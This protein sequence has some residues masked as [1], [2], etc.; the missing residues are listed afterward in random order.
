MSFTRTLAVT[1]LLTASALFGQHDEHHKAVNARGD[2]AMGFSHE[3]TTH[4]FLL[5][6]SG[7]IIRV[8]ANDA[9]DT[10]SRD[11][12]RQHLTHIAMMF[13]AG[14][15]QVPMLIH[16]QVPPGV[17]AM[18]Q[19]KTAISYDFENAAQGAQI[20]ITTKDKK[21]VKAIHAFLRFQISDHK[22][23]DSTEIGK[24]KP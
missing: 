21:A 1:S 12:I 2:Q 23:G 17:P 22:T 11:Q 14:N 15:F 18:K 4:H 7:G 16:D 20:R 24:D 9:A 19:L 3:K 13:T 10:Q 5:T 6:E 8:E